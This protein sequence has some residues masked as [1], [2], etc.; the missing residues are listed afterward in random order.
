M[1]NRTLTDTEYQALLALIRVIDINRLTPAKALTV[2][3]GG[4]VTFAHAI[5]V[6]GDITLNGLL[7]GFGQGLGI[8]D[9]VQHAKV[10]VDKLRL[11]NDSTPVTSIG[12]AGDQKGMVAW[13]SSYIY[14]CTANYDGI[15]NIWKRA[16]I[17][18]TW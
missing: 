14:I 10:T 4:R 7:A 3:L 8:N 12:A 5:H 6:L 18:G 11:Y 9:D 17:G 15:T 2:D 16:A 13:D 1:P